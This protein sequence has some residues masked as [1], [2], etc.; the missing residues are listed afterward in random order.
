MF[1]VWL[2]SNV[3]DKAGERL[4][5]LLRL[6]DWNGVG[7][8]Y[9]VAAYLMFAK[10][11]VFLRDEDWA[12]LCESLEEHWDELHPKVQETLCREDLRSFDCTLVE[13]EDKNFLP[14]A[15]YLPDI[16][17]WIELNMETF[18]VEGWAESWLEQH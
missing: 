7:L 11:E 4:A 3:Q 16:E 5:H 14:G 6:E 18:E 2:E 8:F 10:W 12:S 15:N 13:Q 1:E 17:K 9:H